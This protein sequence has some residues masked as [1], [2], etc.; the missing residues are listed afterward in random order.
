LERALAECGII[1]IHA[2]SPQAKGRIERS[3]GTSRNRLLKIMRLDDVRD[4]EEGNRYL[5]K[6][7]L[8]KWNKKFTREPRSAYNA[9]R[10]ASGFDLK[11]IFSYHALRVVSNDFTFKFEGKRYQ[12]EPGKLKGDIRRGKILVEK[13]LD[14]TV[15]ARQ[16]DCYLTIHPIS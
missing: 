8:P 15:R 12:I 16:D 5:S 13:R 2:H 4:I 10:D 7:Y 9:H 3:H 1:H 6:V 14:G 11:A